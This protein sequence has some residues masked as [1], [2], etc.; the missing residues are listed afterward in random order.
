MKPKRGSN[1]AS[2]K[3]PN[4]KSK[5]KTEQTT[6]K[7]MTE[8]QDQESRA[9]KNKSSQL[10]SAQKTKAPNKRSQESWSL[11]SRSSMVALDNI[12]DLSILSTL[13]L[14]H[15][16]KKDIQEHLNTIKKGFLAECARLK[17]PVRKQREPE[18]SFQHRQEET[19]K[20]LAAKKTLSCLKENLSSVV[21]V[22]EQTEEHIASL[23]QNCNK[24]REKLEDEEEKAKELL[25]LSEQSVLNLP[26]PPPLKDEETLEARIRNIVSD[27]DAEVVAKKLGEILQSS[28]VTQDKQAVLVHANKYAEQLFNHGFSCTS[29]ESYSNGT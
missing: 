2:S 10:K 26:P 12:L 9:N 14:R 15:T 5:E 25:Q 8:P 7:Q 16:S 17:V 4:A 1:R 18:P 20:S 29:E 3:V 27:M 6:R 22:L 11:M 21:S 28:E 24:L 19:N 13:A 23:Q